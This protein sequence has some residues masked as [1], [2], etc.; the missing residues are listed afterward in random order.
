MNLEHSKG[1]GLTRMKWSN[2]RCQIAPRWHACRYD[3][4]QFNIGSTATWMRWAGLSVIGP[5]MAIAPIVVQQAA[6]QTAQLVEWRFD[7]ATRQLELQTAGGTTPNYF[8]LAQPARIVLDLPN[9]VVGPVLEEQSYSGVVRHIRVGQ[10]QPTLTRIVVELAPDA[11]LTPAQV[12]LRNVPAT[13]E[14]TGEATAGDRWVLRPLLAGD[15]PV[16]A[17]EPVPPT[18]IPPGVETP[19]PSVPEGVTLAPGSGLVDD[20]VDEADEEDPNPVPARPAASQSDEANPDEASPDESASSEALDGEAEIADPSSEETAVETATLPP[21]EPGAFEIPVEI[22]PPLLDV[23]ADAAI[24]G[25]GNELEADTDGLESELPVAIAPPPDPV[26]SEDDGP[27]ALE[28]PTSDEP[29]SDDSRPQRE[30]RPESRIVEDIQRELEQALP[31]DTNVVIVRGSDSPDGEVPTDPTDLNEQTPAPDAEA[32]SPLEPAP[33]DGPAPDPVPEQESAQEWLRDPE[34]DPSDTIP[35]P[36]D[37]DSERTPFPAPDGDRPSTPPAVPLDS[38]LLSALPPPVPEDSPPVTVSVPSLEQAEAEASSVIPVSPT[39]PDPAESVAESDDSAAPDLEESTSPEVETDESALESAPTFPTPAE[40][41]PAEPDQPERD[42]TESPVT[43]SDLPEPSIQPSVS[44]PTAVEPEEETATPEQSTP[45]QSASEPASA[46]TGAPQATDSS[47]SSS[48]SV[49]ASPDPAPSPSSASGSPSPIFPSPEPATQS[50]PSP[51]SADTDVPI[52]EFGQPI[53]DLARRPVNP[54]EERPVTLPTTES[55]IPSS[56]APSPAPLS[57]SRELIVAAGP[58]ALIPSGTVL[59]L[60]YPRLTPTVLQTGIAWQDVLLLEQTVRD[61]TGQIIAPEG[62]QI[63]GRFEITDRQ[64]R[65]V[66]QAIA[67]EG[68]NIPLQAI[69]GWVPIPPSSRAVVIRS[70][71]IVNV[72]LA[73]EFS[74]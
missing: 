51:S 62:S 29:R 59:K 10:F 54:A 48:E 26:P 39:E 65:F 72:R 19:E 37:S 49:A 53:R 28:S 45:A 9:T 11:V 4:S 36:S 30:S 2:I 42:A 8:I 18:P 34:S 63:I 25:D 21:L 52:I 60:R 44:D 71:Q 5:L 70:N 1:M 35:A 3:I 32:E 41:V 46:P 6:A 23:E 40:S 15:A 68:R 43:D 64:I 56:V 57:P 12:E 47:T 69:S 33:T 24:D 38:D 58:D 73:S 22:P 7:P 61:R 27:S 74:R 50:E 13:G 31:D 67:L 55:N 17:I 20:A 16:A 66:T 14:A